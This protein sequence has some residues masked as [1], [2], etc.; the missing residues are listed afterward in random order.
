MYQ[1]DENTRKMKSYEVEGQIL[2]DSAEVVFNGTAKNVVDL[3]FLEIN[4]STPSF[5]S[6][7]ATGTLGLAPYLKERGVL[8]RSIMIMLTEK[9]TIESTVFSIYLPRNTTKTGFI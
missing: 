5:V 8:K 6:S 7:S 4:K 2:Q 1:F 9:G 3:Q